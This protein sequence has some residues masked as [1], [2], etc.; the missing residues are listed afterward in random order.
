MVEQHVA[1]V[2]QLEE[3]RARRLDHGQ[4]L[5]RRVAQVRERGQVDEGQE[6]AESSGPAMR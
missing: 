3:L 6:R 1:L 4:R 5:E 2:E